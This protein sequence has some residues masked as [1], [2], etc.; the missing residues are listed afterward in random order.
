MEIGR[1]ER[2]ARFVGGRTGKVGVLR[3]ETRMFV[4]DAI[5]RLLRETRQFAERSRFVLLQLAREGDRVGKF[6]R[7]KVRRK[8]PFVHRRVMSGVDRCRAIDAERLIRALLTDAFVQQFFHRTLEIVRSRTDFRALE[9]Q[10]SR[11]LTPLE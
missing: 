10:C 8:V 6:F 9:R 11:P 3:L 2:M 7:G 1:I 4:R 5:A